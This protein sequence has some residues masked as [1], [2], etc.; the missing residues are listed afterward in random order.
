MVVCIALG[1]DHRLEGVPARPYISGGHRV[2]GKV[3]AEYSWSPTATQSGSFLYTAASST[4]IRVIT[5]EVSVRI[6]GVS[7]PRGGGG[8]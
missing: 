4:P 7:D 5:G 8:E 2:T 3:L 1:I 6:T